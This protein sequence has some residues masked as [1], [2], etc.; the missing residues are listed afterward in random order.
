MIQ[1]ISE[2]QQPRVLVVDDNHQ[3]LSAMRELL[4]SRGYRA[5]LVSS[6]EEAEQHICR[7]PPDLRKHCLSSISQPI[8]YNW[9]TMLR[10]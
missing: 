1:G 5:C 3:N 6:A 2:K 4:E 9:H 7:H 10:V 8:G